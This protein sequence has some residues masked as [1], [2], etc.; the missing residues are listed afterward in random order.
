MTKY[1]KET[2]KIIIMANW[3]PNVGALSMDRWQLIQLEKGKC[4][5]W[6]AEKIRAYKDIYD[7]TLHCQN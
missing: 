7:N 1:S 6:S 4:H 2:I 3:K 5:E